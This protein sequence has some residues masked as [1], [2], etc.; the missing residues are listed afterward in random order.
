LRQPPLR[1]I[2]SKCSGL[3]GGS[4][5][6]H[7]RLALLRIAQRGRCNR[8]TICDTECV[9]HKVI[10]SRSSSS[11]QR[12]I[13]GLGHGGPQRLVPCQ[14][15]R[16]ATLAIASFP[17][18]RTRACALPACRPSSWVL[19]AVVVVDREREGLAMSALPYEQT[20]AAPVGMSQRCHNR[21]HARGKHQSISE[22]STEWDVTSVTRFPSIEMTL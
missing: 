3:C 16:V 11:V 6:R 13:S 9:G 4:P 18:R 2:T 8:L 7:S 5:F 1:R 21:T 19:S 14:P 17:Q 20:S 10:S 15:I 12:D 22:A